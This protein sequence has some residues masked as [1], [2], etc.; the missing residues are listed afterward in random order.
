MS[1]NAP[2]DAPLSIRLKTRDRLLEHGYVEKDG[3][4]FGP[5]CPKEL[6]DRISITRPLL[7]K[8]RQSGQRSTGVNDDVARD[9]YEAADRLLVKL[10][11]YVAHQL[12]AYEALA[13]LIEGSQNVVTAHELGTG[14]PF[15][16]TFATKDMRTHGI[17]LVLA[18]TAGS[19]SKL[20]LDRTSPVATNLADDFVRYR[21]GLVFGK[22]ADRILRQ[23]WGAGPVW[24]AAEA[25]AEQGLR[26]SIGDGDQGLWKDDE[27]SQAHHLM[28]GTNARKQAR[29]LFLTTRRSMLSKMDRE[30][31]NERGEVAMVDGYLP[32]SLPSAPPPGLTRIV[33]RDRTQGGSVKRIYLD[34]PKA[35]PSSRIALSALPAARKANGKR[36]DQV[37]NIRWYLKH[38][39]TPEWSISALGRELVKRGYSTNSVRDL[40][41]PTATASEKKLYDMQVTIWRNLEL[42]ETGRFERTLLDQTISFVDV[43][44]LDGEPWATPQDFERIR[45]WRAHQEARFSRQASHTFT[46]MEV[47]WDGNAYKL[48]PEAIPAEGRP[49]ETTV[50]YYL[51]R[52]P[53]ASSGPTKTGPGSRP[54]VWLQH[55]WIA[56]AILRALA[57]AQ[58]VPA[59]RVTL[60]A[61]DEHLVELRDALTKATRAHAEAES[62]IARISRDLDERLPGSME[63]VMPAAARKRKWNELVDLEA[64]L[65]GLGNGMNN[66]QV[67]VD[68]YVARLDVIRRGLEVASAADVL[69]SLLNPHET[70]YRRLWREAISNFKVSSARLRSYNLTGR[71]V[72][73]TFDLHVTHGE[74]T[75]NAPATGQ[76]M[77]GALSRLDGITTRLFRDLQE[78]LPLLPDDSG[79][80]RNAVQALRVRLGCTDGRTAFLNCRHPALL[81]LGMS[82]LFPPKAGQPG[83]LADTTAD[84]VTTRRAAALRDSSEFVDIFTRPDVLARRIMRVYTALPVNYKHHLHPVGEAHALAL[85]IALHRGGLVTVADITQRRFWE[86]RRSIG[87]GPWSREW[88]FSDSHMRLAP[89]PGCGSQRRTAAVLREVDG[90][91]CLDCRQDTSGVTWP[92]EH[93]DPYLVDE[94]GVAPVNVEARPRAIGPYSRRPVEV[95][96]GPEYHPQVKDNA[97]KYVPPEA[98]EAIVEAYQNGT[99]MRAI[100]G[101]FELNRKDVSLLLHSRNMVAR[102][103]RSPRT[104]QPPND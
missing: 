2:G 87:R 103:G 94:H 9:V 13:H 85:H 88:E 56:E 10:D 7:L 76:H 49:G 58:T 4:L 41:G 28:N 60:D 84:Y 67:A 30:A 63:H 32:F 26:L 66:A 102:S 20:D 19:A 14:E 52:S 39:G 75:V 62:S 104:L 46:G 78:G 8:G 93:F 25:L 33:V 51:S 18:L 101:R 55:D 21:P 83:V 98:V 71:L 79:P 100:A 6:V 23:G 97:W 61:D 42:Y 92:A 64:R 45:R 74:V 65:P 86:L 80:R 36:A 29:A 5:H 31:T 57:R 1:K 47:E 72:D 54:G 50:K 96:S 95:A 35:Y 34:T 70:T 44:P 22:R 89:C 27:L 24:I 59:A 77:L 40:H 3:L 68:D 82:V 69:V 43:W 11:I 12:P 91:V 90:F 38:A 53:N 17:G 81:R 15:V 73:F 16:C 99:S 37:K 48:V